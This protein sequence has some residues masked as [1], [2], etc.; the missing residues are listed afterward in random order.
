M[1]LSSG[2]ALLLI[3]TG[4]FER[5]IAIAACLYMV[6]YGSGFLSLFIL[7]R[8]EPSLARPFRVPGYPWSAAVPLVGSALFLAGSV[9]GDTTNSLYALGLMAASY[10]AYLWLARG[11][12]AAAPL[13]L[14]AER[15]RGDRSERDRDSGHRRDEPR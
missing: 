5:L 3:V 8:K 10:P 6:V 2:L 15:A 11:G 14:Q 7:R 13:S 4:T 1:L 9:L 12:G